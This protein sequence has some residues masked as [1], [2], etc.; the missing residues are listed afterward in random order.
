MVSVEHA[1]FVI[2]DKITKFTTREPASLCLGLRGWKGNL[3]F[4]VDRIAGGL[5]TDGIWHTKFR[6]PEGK[7]SR[8]LRKQVINVW[9]DL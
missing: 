5:P 7:M 1:W 8:L 3:Q 6:L 4:A 9:L 2:M